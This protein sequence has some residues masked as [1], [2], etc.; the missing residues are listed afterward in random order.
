MLAAHQNEHHGVRNGR[1]WQLIFTTTTT[2]TTSKGFRLHHHHHRR[3]TIPP[4]GRQRGARHHAAAVTRCW[5]AHSHGTG[6]ILIYSMAFGSAQL[7]LRARAQGCESL[8]AAVAAAVAMWGLWGS[9]GR[10]GG[11]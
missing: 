5:R 2:T 6:A 9:Q 8:N 11:A 1:I 4:S 3:L 7:N 10:A